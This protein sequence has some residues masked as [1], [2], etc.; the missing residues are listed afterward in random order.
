MEL[1]SSKAGN[2]SQDAPPSLR[3][4][5]EP[6]NF[7]FTSRL[8]PMY[9]HDAHIDDPSA[10]AEL[11][12]QCIQ[13]Q[14][15]IGPAIQGTAKEGVNHGFQFGAGMRDLALGD[16]L[17]AKRLRPTTRFEAGRM[18]ATVPCLLAE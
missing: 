10:L 3:P 17:A 1:L 15:G 12:G 5:V 7:R 2:A 14:V 13:P 6:G 16:A 11:P 8:T 4:H 18:L 9:D